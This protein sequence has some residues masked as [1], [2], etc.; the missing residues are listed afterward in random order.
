MDERLLVLSAK[1]GVHLWDRA[2]GRDLAFLPLGENRAIW[3]PDGRSLITS[4]DRGLQSW[5]IRAER[6]PNDSGAE[7]AVRLSLGPAKDL[8]AVDRYWAAGLTADGRKLA[9]VQRNQQR[10]VVVDLVNGTQRRTTFPHRGVLRAAIS[11]DGKWLATGTW[12]NPGK[13]TTKIWDART[14]L[15]TAELPPDLIQGDASVFFSPDGRWLVTSQDAEFRIWQVGSWQPQRVFRRE[16]GYGDGTV[17]FT[18]EG[19]LMAINR[20]PELLELVDPAT[21]RLFATL[22]V[23][24][25]SPIGALRFSADGS[26]L[27]VGCVIQPAFVWDLRSVREGLAPLGLDWD[28]P[29]YP[30]PAQRRFAG[31]LAIHVDYP[32]P[33]AAIGMSSL[34]LA[35]NPF[36][37]DAYYQRGRAYGALKRP[38]HAIADYSMFLTLAPPTDQRRPEVL[39]RR[40][41]C[42]MALNRRAESLADM[43]QIAQGRPDQ[44]GTLAAE[45][46]VRCNDLAWQLANGPEKERDL[47]SALRLIGMAFKLQPDG[48]TLWNTLGAVHYRSGRYQEAVAALER[49]LAV[50]QGQSDAFDLFFLALCHAK[51]GEPARARDCFDRA[52]KWMEEQKDLPAQHVEELKAF[53]AEAEAAL[54]TP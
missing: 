16:S 29:P 52:V 43:L 36:N 26:Q 35:L 37:W 3:H 51:L 9:A 15:L 54:R 50:G 34:A 27:A 48:A 7:F 31:P 22:T 2:E 33:K 47:G 40:S 20:N 24:D 45:A 8:A 38:I 53:R 17:A 25:R 28:L 39:F 6:G 41:N 5:P 19:R 13:G 1:N 32:D 46:S 4:S 30:P 12:H 44:F 49:S 42:F 14:G 10:A 18:R 11:P 23:P 21:G